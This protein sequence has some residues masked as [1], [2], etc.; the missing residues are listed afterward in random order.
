MT[1]IPWSLS[2]SGILLTTLATGAC[3]TP[4]P[5]SDSSDWTTH[6]PPRAASTQPA[7]DA[8]AAAWPADEPDLPF[9]EEE[10]RTVAQVLLADPASYRAP[11]ADNI[12][13][14]DPSRA[15]LEPDLAAAVERAAQALPPGLGLRL[16]E[17]YR[18][19]EQQLARM[20]SNCEKPPG[21][22]SCLPQPAQP[23]T[24]M[25]RLDD[26][27]SCPHTTGRAADILGLRRVADGT[28]QQCVSQQQCLTGGYS[29]QASTEACLDDPCQAAVVAAMR[30]A[31]FCVHTLQPWHFEQPALT[32]A[33]L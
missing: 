24:C 30:R 9:G 19:P 12:V 26:R 14:A 16:V 10:A 21:H 22:K 17:G 5:T 27:H 28:W 23:P 4:R 20:R 3:R 6:L 32:A 11:Q 33:C 13:L 29:L 8:S 25:L 1:G 18:T 31:G 2:V 15:R 7:A